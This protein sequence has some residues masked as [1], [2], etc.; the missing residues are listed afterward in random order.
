M[1]SQTEMGNVLLD[2][3]EKAFVYKMAKNLAELCLGSSVLWKLELASNEIVYLAKEISK[4]SIRG[5]AWFFL[6]IVKCKEK[7]RN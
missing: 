6:F 1:R 2:N 5:V 7:E 4:Q 3:R